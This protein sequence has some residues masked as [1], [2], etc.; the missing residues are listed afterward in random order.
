ME[1][2][3]ARQWALPLRIILGVSFMIHGAPKLFSG[4]AHQQ[5]QGMLAHLGVPGAPAMAWVIGIVEFFGGVALVLGL[6]TWLASALLTVEMIVAMLLV[7]LPAGWAAVHVTG[8]S[9]RGPVFG[10]PGYEL[11]LLYIAGLL[12][13]LL[14]GPGPLSVDARAGHGETALHAPW[15]RRRAHA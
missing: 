6:F 10:L 12:A 5:F 13:L 1:H 15:V 2:G 9:E 8:M 7:H 14:G 11:N 4:A 3:L